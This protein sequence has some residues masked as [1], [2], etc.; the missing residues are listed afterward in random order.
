VLAL[1]ELGGTVAVKLS[2]PAVQHKSEL[3][4]V[5]L[6]VRD[7]AQVRSAYRRL[8]ELGVSVLVERMAA[9]GV[10]LIVAARTDAVVPAL[11]IGLG[12]IWTE[13][14][15]DVAILPLPASAARIERAL[16]SL[17]GAPLLT[18]GRGST[19]VDLGAVARIAERVGEVLIEDGLELI[20]LNPVL[21]S[22]EGAVAVDASIR[23]RVGVAS[24]AAATPTPIPLGSA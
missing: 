17:R 1:A 2:D 12:G 19:P 8:S 14:L 24:R 5:Y 22:P 21:V 13:V 9:P 4:A 10:E 16:S 15:G 18:G 6:G 20:E 3:G 7:E 23:R 11:V